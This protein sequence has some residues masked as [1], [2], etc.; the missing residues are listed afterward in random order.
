MASKKVGLVLILSIISLL[1]LN[2]A[3]VSSQL[4]IKKEVVSPVAIKDLNIPAEYT[5]TITNLG[6]SDTFNIYSLVGIT[7]QPNES[8][9]LG[10][11]E[12]KVIDLKAYPPLELK[13][14]PD[15]YSFDYKI[16]GQKA[17]IQS[18]ELAITLVY[19]KDAFNFYVDD[20][21]PESTNA[22]VH[23]DNRGG[24]VFSNINLDLSSAFFTKTL[25]FPLGAFEKKT[26]EIPID[27]EKSRVLVA[28]PY[29]LNAK[30]S[31]E[32]VD[33]ATS[34]VMKFTEAANIETKQTD[35]GILFNR[36]E[37]EKLNKGNTNLD[38]STVITRNKFTSLFTTFN[39]KPTRKESKGFTN[40]FIFDAQVAPGKSLDV[41][42]K[43]D[44]WILIGIIVAI[45]LIW[46]I[47][48]KYIRNKLILRKTVGFVR[49]KGGEFALRINVH[50]KARDFVEKIKI[51]DR[52]PPMVKVFE[53]YGA[54]APDRIDENS[55]RIEWNIAALG[56]GEER[57]FSYIV[58]SKVGVMGRF[59]LPAAGAIY[60]FQ[61]KIKEA[62]S[63][64]AFFKNEPG[65]KKD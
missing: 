28:G 13:V 44:W 48:D 46:Y 33:T 52:L 22:I 62:S 9:T 36:V 20:I 57:T 50:L 42:A 23:F 16:A 17:G 31:A 53:R 25:S 10:A 61:G 65:A 63:N 34:V 58:Y 38:V 45:I 21:N 2:L 14:S 41:I 43:T 51:I 15:Y 47:T 30:I 6:A 56:K 3:V 39:I 32:G 1:L 64:Q 40:T 27:K 8:F 11:N 12:V 37:V 4:D 35:E 19:L 49:T 60:E 5:L 24:H 18:D 54:F 29:I 55:R 26:I 59:E 7:L